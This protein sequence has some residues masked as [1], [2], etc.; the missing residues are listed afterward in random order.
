M[1]ASPQTAGSPFL[2]A[3]L[4]STMKWDMHLMLHLPQSMKPEKWI[5]NFEIM[6]ENKLFM[7]FWSIG[8]KVY[9][10]HLLSL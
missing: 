2:P 10:H 8:Q 7:L 4:P 6:R 1:A 5:E 9:Y 3:L